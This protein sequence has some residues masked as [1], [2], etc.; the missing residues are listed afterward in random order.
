MTY[1]KLG[2]KAAAKKDL[3]KILVDDPK[4]AGVNEALASL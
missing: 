4:A 3:E 1:K 2:K